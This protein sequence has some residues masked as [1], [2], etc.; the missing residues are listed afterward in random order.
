MC[1]RHEG[2]GE[3]DSVGRKTVFCGPKKNYD[4]ERKFLGFFIKGLTVVRAS[5]AKSF[6]LAGEGHCNSG[7]FPMELP[8]YFN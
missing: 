5:I 8:Y 3:N 4:A 6:N 1:F 7:R 2:E